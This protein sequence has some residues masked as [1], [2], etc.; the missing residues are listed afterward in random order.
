MCEIKCS[1]VLLAMY[2][3]FFFH[4]KLSVKLLEELLT[5]YK[6]QL[7]SAARYNL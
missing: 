4:S 3:L 7:S 2:E 1:L 6:F 5:L